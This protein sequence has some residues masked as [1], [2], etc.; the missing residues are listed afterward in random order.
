M[1]LMNKV[2]MEYLDK[3]C[4]PSWASVSFGWKK[5]LSLGILSPT[6]ESQWTQVK[7]RT[8]WIGIRSRM[9]LK[10]EVSSDS[11]VTTEDSLKDSRRSWNPSLLCWKRE[12]IQMGCRMSDLFWGTENQINHC[13][14]IDIARYSQRVWCL[15]WCFP[16]RP[17]MC[18]NAREKSGSLCL[19]T[20]EKAWIELSYTWFRIS[21]RCAC[22]EDLETLYDG[23]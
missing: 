23:E 14:N 6:E 4:T 21:C 3:C 18:A 2:F 22:T 16:P 10:S 11:Q 1:Y 7:F 19:K 17:R 9:C 5:F 8:C 20:I 12:R 13:P 15:L